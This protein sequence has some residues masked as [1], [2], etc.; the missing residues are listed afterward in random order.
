MYLSFIKA[1]F[2]V[3]SIS[4]VTGEYIR[5]CYVTSWSRY[6][7]GMGY[8]DISKHYEN[9]LCTHL[10]Y[11]FGKVVVGNNGG[12]EIQPFEADDIKPNGGFEQVSQREKNYLS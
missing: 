2:A 6:R 1:F 7:R 10:I 8:F 3:S 12:Y 9:G 11:S 5:A 4:I